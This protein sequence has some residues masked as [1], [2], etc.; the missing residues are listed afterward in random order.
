MATETTKTDVAIVGA[1]TAGAATALQCARRGLRVV[2]LDRRPAGQTGARWVNGVPAW[3]YDETGVPTSEPPELR[4]HAGAL[5]LL[6]GWGPARVI[7]EGH[8]VLEVD[9]RALVDRLTALAREAGAEVRYEARALGLDGDV[10]RTT[11]GDIR[12]D[13]IVD[14]SGLG[15]AGLA[16]V[17]PVAPEDICAAAQGVFRVADR[18]AAQAWFRDHGAR[19]GDAICFSGVAGGYSI[20]N[21][22]L[23]GDEVSVLT[24]SLPALG[25]PSGAKLL[26]DA[27]ARHRW[28]GPKLFGGASPIPLRRPC[29]HLVHGRVALVGDAAGQV[30]ATHGSGVAAQLVAAATLAEVLAEGAG[31]Q[32][33]QHRWQRRWGGLF[34][35]SDLFRRFTTT[36]RPDEV[37]RLFTSGVMSPEVARD[38]LSQR[39]PRPDAGKLRGVL[40]ALARDPWTV[41]KMAPLIG[42][43]AFATGA[44]RSFPAAPERVDAWERRMNRVLGVLAV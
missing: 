23:H 24:G 27:L 33:Y 39:W 36:L 13:V 30:F 1:G 12:A 31:L 20:V 3:V 25:Y 22:R 40:R 4:G 8:D 9:M 29:A 18:A 11:T 2:C 19:P 28:I 7:V 38:G 42:R 37:A 35:A 5:H 21:L 10:L 44:W 26:A 15:G 32:A 16:P 34:A 43:I 6:A 17:P 14:A 41:A